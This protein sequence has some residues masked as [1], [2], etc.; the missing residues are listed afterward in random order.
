M[1]PDMPDSPARARTS[2]IRARLNTAWALLTEN[3]VLL[4]IAGIGFSVSFQ[5]IAREAHA[6]EMPG[7]SVLYPL[8]ID[9]CIAGFAI[10]ARKAIDDGCS[11]LVPRLLAWAGAL[12]TLYVNAHGSPPGDWLGLTLHIAAPCTWIAFLELTRW[13]KLRRKRAERQD[14]IPLAR[15]LTEPRRTAGMRRRMVRHNITC[16]PVAVAREEARL[17]A[18][19]LVRA[20]LGRRWKRKAPALLRHHLVTG[21]LPSD[22]AQ[23]CESAAYGR[24]VI[25]EP[26]EKWVTDALTAGARTAAR[27]VRE[28]RQIEASAAPADASPAASQTRPH[29]AQG[30]VSSTEAERVRARQVISAN[31][32]LSRRE[33]A[34][35]ARVSESTIT[36]V[37][38][39]PRRVPGEQA[40][41]PLAEVRSLR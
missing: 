13:R 8:L 28:T 21:T 4:V 40:D 32:H 30:R 18:I 17:L 27:V 31:P 25:A 41:E 26:A 19:D 35:L 39:E 34:A 1:M 9:A 24:A 16:Y 20:S 10:E 3:P 12:L 6:Q 37:K 15:W 14:A 38:K 22:L 33:Q 23:A 7:P 11:D 2:A 29:A 5:T 36:R